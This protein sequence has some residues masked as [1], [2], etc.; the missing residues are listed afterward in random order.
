MKALGNIIWFILIGWWYGIMC[1][2]CGLLC[3]IT[4][5]GIPFGVAY[6]RIAKPA[7][8]PFGKTITTDY[9]EHPKGNVV[10]MV[11]G[12]AGMA[13][14]MAVVGAILCVTIIGIP[15]AKQCFKLARI[16]ALPFGATV[17]K[18]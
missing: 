7:F 13:V 10:W 14:W 12:G 4:I 2:L 11:L 17:E 5:I 8:L 15:L 1:W 3:C 6:F 9:Q 16:C 18:E